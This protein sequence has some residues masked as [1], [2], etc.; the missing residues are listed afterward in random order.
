[1]GLPP[2]DR[3][4]PGGRRYERGMKL[5]FLPVVN[6]DFQGALVSCRK[7]TNSEERIM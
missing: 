4:E 3:Q 1:M 6:S 2:P 5:E 7:D